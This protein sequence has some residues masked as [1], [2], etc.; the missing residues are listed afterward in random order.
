[1]YLVLQIRETIEVN[2]RSAKQQKRCSRKG[3]TDPRSV[4]SRKSAYF[5]VGNDK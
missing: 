3:E 1:M 4:K 5:E 2:P